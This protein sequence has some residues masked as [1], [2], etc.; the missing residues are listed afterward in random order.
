[1]RNIA[2]GRWLLGAG[3][4]DAVTYALCAPEHNSAIWRRWAEIKPLFTFTG[5][6][7]TELP[8][9]TVLSYHRHA[10]VEALAHRYRI[11]MG[12]ARKQAGD[13]LA[14]SLGHAVSVLGRAAGVLDQ[15]ADPEVARHELL[16]L[17][18]TVHLADAAESAAEHARRARE[19]AGP[20]RANQPE[21]RRPED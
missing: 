4:A 6:E 14:W 7:L 12:D 8:A 3:Q 9:T 18:D 5:V 2:L 20:V 1:M 17:A 10:D 15:I 19:L 16:P 21:H 13:R 11:D